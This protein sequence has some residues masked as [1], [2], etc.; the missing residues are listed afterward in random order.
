MIEAKVNPDSTNAVTVMFAWLASSPRQNTPQRQKRDIAVSVPN[1]VQLALRLVKPRFAFS[2]CTALALCGVLLTAIPRSAAAMEGDHALFCEGITDTSETVGCI[3]KELDFH[4]AAV[5]T[6]YQTLSES[7]DGDMRKTLAD[8]QQKWLAYRDAECEWEEGWA[9]G[10]S[11]SRVYELSCLASL[12]RERSERL[13]RAVHAA[14]PD[15]Q[16]EFA[17]TARWM[18]TLIAQNT[19]VFWNFNTAQQADMNCDGSA[20]R[21]V[22]GVALS[23]TALAMAGPANGVNAAATD[24]AAPHRTASGAGYGLVGVAHA[25]RTGKPAVFIMMMNNPASMPRDVQNDQSGESIDIDA[26]APSATPAIPPKKP[27]LTTNVENADHHSAMLFPPSCASGF[28]VEAVKQATGASADPSTDTTAN[29][30][31]NAPS[32]THA[33]RFTD[34]TCPALFVT[35][36]SVKNLYNLSSLNPLAHSVSNPP[37]AAQAPKTP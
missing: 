2:V 30:T 15:T 20:D 19:R 26:S 1:A 34:T 10:Q 6:L 28:T 23:Q 36:D 9:K 11:L 8:N 21:L 35:W 24:K 27:D 5:N 17:G 12:T 33:L 16:P 3:K 7:M 31:V 32:C 37:T 14:A 29:T 22:T 13:L 4:Q 25:S 18:S